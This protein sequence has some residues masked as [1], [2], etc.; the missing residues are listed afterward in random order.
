MNNDLKNPLPNPPLIRE[1]SKAPD[2]A[3]APSPDKGR[4]GGVSSCA[5][6]P[7]GWETIKLGFIAKAITKGTTPT[8]AGFRYKEEG[9]PFVKVENINDNGI[10]LDS[11]SQYIG[12]DAHDFLARSQFKE[13]D[14]LFSIAGTIGKTALVK[15][16]HLPANTNQAVAI[17]RGVTDYFQENFLRLQLKEKADQIAMSNARGGAMKNI[18]LGD[19][20]SLDVLIPPLPEQIRIANKLDSLLVKVET[21]QTR[22]ENIPTLLKRFRQ[23]V[24]VAATS[25]ELTREWREENSLIWKIDQITV[26]LIAKNEKYSLGIGPFGSNLKVVD[27]RDE[28]H[29]LVFVREIRANNFGREGTKF[30]DDDKFA[31]LVAHRVK[32]GSLLI[33]KMGDPPGDVAI[34]PENRPEGI[35]TSDCIKL[36]VDPEKANRDFVYLYLQS[37]PF[38]TQIQNITA[39]VAQQKVNLKK[40]RELL[41][42]LPE[43]EEQAE[44]VRRV[45]SLFAMAD[46]VERQYQ[47][48]KARL[49]KLTQAILAKAFRGELVPQDPDDEPASVLLQRIQTERASPK[50]GS[51]AHA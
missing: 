35:I 49:D 24:L 43:M 9:V 3:S 40:F 48:A 46:T 5:A 42:N 6:L 2:S 17:I 30:V 12:N 37:K 38:Q 4:S 16:E 33:T 20:K 44:I 15:K 41:I 26:N 36:D 21:A 51:K 28:G 47:A 18:S 25:G 45:E 32:P 19:L 14:I 1:G 39:G 13:N 50:P 11:I 29:P 27:Y 8:T 23:A 10:N 31:E 34:Y 7:P 22:L